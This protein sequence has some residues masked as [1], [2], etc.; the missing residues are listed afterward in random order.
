MDTVEERGRLI[1]HLENAL[2]I[3]DEIQDSATGFLI[4]RALDE[5]RSRQFQPTGERPR[6]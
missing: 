1:A 2:A 5:A 4:E 3:A 6:S